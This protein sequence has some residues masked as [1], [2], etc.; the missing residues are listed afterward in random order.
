MFI[1]RFEWTSAGSKSLTRSMD[2]FVLV[3]V[4]TLCLLGSSLAR[5]LFGVP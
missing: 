2:C 3:K 5:K 4:A 1:T